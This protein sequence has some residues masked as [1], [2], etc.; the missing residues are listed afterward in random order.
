MPNALE[1]YHK[2]RDFK[3][4]A[5]P[6]GKSKIKKDKKQLAFVVQRH[7]ATRLHYDFRLELN[8][9]LK[10]WAVPKGPSLNPADKRLAVMVEDHPYDYKDFYGSIPEGN[11][12]A[13]EVEIWDEGF[14]FPVNENHQAITEA[15]AAKNLDKGELKVLMAGTHLQGEFVLVRLKGD[16]KN[17]LLIKHKDDYSIYDEYDI[18]TISSIKSKGKKKL[19]KTARKA[20]NKSIDLKKKTATADNSVNK[21]PASK[22]AIKKSADK[23]APSKKAVNEKD[24]PAK[25]PAI[26]SLKPMLAYTASEAFDDA[27]WLFEYKWDGYRTIAIKTGDDVQLLSRNELSFNAKYPA[28]V[29]AVTESIDHDVVLDGEIVAMV[30]GKPSFQALQHAAE[31][32]PELRYCIFDLLYLDGQ[33]VMHLPLTDRKK[34]LE[35][36]LEKAN[37]KALY[38]SGHVFKNGKS[39]FNKIKKAD[40]EGIIAKKADSTY[41]PNMRSREWL[42][43]KNR[44]DREAIIVGY[45]EGSGSRSYFGA[46]ILAEKDGK[47]YRYLGHTGTGFN[48]ASLKEL[49]HKMQPLVTDKSPFNSKIKVNAPVTWITPKL[50]CTIYFTEVTNEGMLRHPVYAG[51]RPDKSVDEVKKEPEKI[52]PGEVKKEADNMEDIEEL[53]AG[54]QKLVI[55]KK[56]IPVTNLD[57]IYFPQEKITKGDVI[58]Y[59]HSIAAYI[60]PHLKNRPMSLKRNPNGIH[61]E[62]FFHKNAGDKAPSWVK[63]FESFS[64]SS[65]R[66]IEYV[67]CNDLATLIYL[68]NLGCIEMNPW[69]STYQKPDHPTWLVIDLDPSDGNT[70]DQVIETALAVKEVTDKAGIDCYCKTSGASGLHIY[71]PLGNRYDYDVVKNFAE[72][73]AIATHELVPDF[74][75]VER[76]LKKRGEKIYVDF[77]QNRRNQTLASAYSLRPV[78]AGS[79]STPLEWKEV[80]KGLH[81]SQFTIFHIEERLSTTGDLFANVL[82]GKNDIKKAMKLLNG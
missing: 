58:A 71:L 9:T 47:D 67:L 18:E 48:E 3:Q 5:E 73:L 39:V 61:G 80:K 37:N 57:K 68:A 2:K 7:D 78:E 1:A 21:R 51:L 64:E 59:Y 16:D 23:K 70:F 60:L 8:G 27:D 31:V 24:I 13:G 17:W 30:N 40:F 36:L 12:G 66:T 52:D 44:N 50:V 20:A 62:S 22:T 6:A 55:D 41:T 81:P 25:T 72:M 29:K 11:Y 56:T 33:P 42:K 15:Q 54:K 82:T 32:K 46:L 26:K 65:N 10:S 43:I 28:I 19:A 75:S 49:Y 74:T 14:Y 35:Q 4:T 34:L 69:N 77:L 45:T 53:T 76:N 63:T 79:I 38:Y